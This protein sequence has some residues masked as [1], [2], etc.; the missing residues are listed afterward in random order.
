MV[1]KLLQNWDGDAKVYAD[2]EQVARH[3][4]FHVDVRRLFEEIGAD[5]TAESWASNRME[6]PWEAAPARLLVLLFHDHAIAILTVWL[7]CDALD[8]GQQLLLIFLLPL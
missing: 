8:V 1:H 7:R 6:P 4:R 3:G 2:P 5:G